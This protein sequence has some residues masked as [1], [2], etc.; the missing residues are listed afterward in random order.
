MVDRWEGQAWQVKLAGKW[1]DFGTDED[2]QIK[3]A[4][5]AGAPK[6]TLQARKYY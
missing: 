5:I 3:Q 1:R 2:K 4:Y 6:F